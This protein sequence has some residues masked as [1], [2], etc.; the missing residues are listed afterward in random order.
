VA[1]LLSLVAM[2]A[3]LRP[4]RLASRIDPTALLRQE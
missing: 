4:A 3:A 2:G 1:V